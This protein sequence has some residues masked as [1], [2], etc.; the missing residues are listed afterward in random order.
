MKCQSRLAMGS[1]EICRQLGERRRRNVHGF[2]NQLIAD[3]RLAC[4]RDMYLSFLSLPQAMSDP[5]GDRGI[6]VFRFIEGKTIQKPDLELYNAVRPLGAMIDVYGKNNVI[7]ERTVPKHAVVLETFP[8]IH[9]EAL[10]QLEVLRA[11]GS[12]RYR[13]ALYHFL[14]ALELDG[15]QP[16]P[17]TPYPHVLQRCSSNE[18]HLPSN[19]WRDICR[20]YQQHGKVSGT[21]AEHELSRARGIFG[22]Q[23]EPVPL[24]LDQLSNHRNF[25]VGQEMYADISELRQRLAHASAQILARSRPLRPGPGGYY[26]RYLRRAEP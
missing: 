10:K 26:F 9:V 14:W 23:F 13:P 17:T 6:G 4:G 3:R 5:E 12:A 1:R 24:D 2:F 11:S 8:W 22:P 25:G 19:F 15:V 20:E 16:Y 18:R 7:I 21:V